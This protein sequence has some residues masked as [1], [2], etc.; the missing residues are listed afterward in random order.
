MVEHYYS[1][2]Q[3]SALKKKFLD[4]KVVRDGVSLSLKLESAAGLFSKDRLDNATKLLI[5]NAIIHDDWRVLDLGCGYGA[6]GICLKRFFPGLKIVMSDVNERAVML[7]RKN[8]EKLDIEVVQSDVFENISGS[9]NAIILNPP[10]AAG[11]E[12]CFRMVRESSLHL[13][14]GGLLEVVARHQKGGKT[15][16]AEMERVFGNVKDVKKSGG[17]RVYV[18][19]R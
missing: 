11:R 7:A 13:E 4:I 1:E 5:E 18:S 16:K 8:A 9:F 10:Y 19:E 6:V 2:K 3:S 15:L 12:L 17:F 14:K